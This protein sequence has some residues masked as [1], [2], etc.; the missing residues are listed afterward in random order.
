MTDPKSVQTS[1]KPDEYD[2]PQ[3]NTY[4]K[5]RSSH[6]GKVTVFKNYLESLLKSKKPLSDL[7]IIQLS[8]RLESYKSL[9]NEFDKNQ[10]LIDDIV[11]VSD[12]QLRE[13][14]QF[15]IE[16]Q[17][18]LALGIHLLR[19]NETAC[20]A[21]SV[22]TP[23]AG[24][25]ATKAFIKLPTIDLPH[26]SGEYQNW[27]EYRD[28]F[29]S[30]IHN[31]KSIDDIQ[32]F[33]YLRASLQGE[34]SDIIKSLEMS[35]HNYRVAWELITERYN[36]THQLIYNHL[37]ALF[38]IQNIEKESA[39]SL[40]Q[41]LD[42]VNKNLRALNNLGEP[43][44]DTILIYLITSKL[45]FT[46]LRYWKESSKNNTV[47]KPTLQDLK[48]YLSDRFMLLQN[49]EDT[50]NIHENIQQTDS[51][52]H[53]SKSDNKDKQS[54][55]PCP[56]CK[57][58]HFLF[59]CP[60]FKQMTVEKRI[61]KV[62]KFSNF[63]ANCLHNGHET[64]S[65]RGGACKYCQKK[66]NTMLHI[67]KEPTKDTAHTTLASNS[68]SQH[69]SVL[70]S[71]ALVHVI[72][73]DGTP[74][75]ARV[76][77]DSGSTSCYIT[78][79][80]S[81]KLNLT[82]EPIR[83]TVSGINQQHTKIFHRTN[84][85]IKSLHGSFTVNLSCLV[86]DTIAHSLPHMRINTQGLNI[87]KHLKLAD[88]QFYEP[89]PID[90]LLGADI[91]WQII[92]SGHIRLGKQQPTLQET[93]LG[94][95]VSGCTTNTDKHT[96]SCFFNNNNSD[97]LSRFWE[98]DSLSNS[99]I[100][101][102]SESDACE[103]IFTQTTTRQSDG[104]FVVNIPFK[105]SPDCL[106][107]S[108]YQAKKRFYSI[109]NRM[110]SN[111]TYKQQ[112]SN[113]ITEYIQLGHMTLNK[114]LHKN[115]HIH[116]EHNTSIIHSSANSTNTNIQHSPVYYLPHHGI[117]RESSTTTKFRAV[118]DGSAKTS[119]K[120]ALNDIQ[121]VG[122]VVQD[123][124]IS[125]LIRFRQHKYIIS[126]DI[127]K[128]FR[129]ITVAEHQ[130]PLQQIIWRYNPTEPL[131]TYMLNTVTYGTASAPFLATRCIKQIG[132]D[133][134]NTQNHSDSYD[135][136]LVSEIILHDF[137]CDD[138]LTGIDD[139]SVLLE[140]AKGVFSELQK[141][142]FPLRKWQSNCPAVL[143]KL[144]FNDSDST[145]FNLSSNDPSKTLGIYW[146]INKDTISYTVHSEFVSQ[147]QI[148]KRT[149]LSTI[150]HIFDPLGLISPCVL[151]AKLIMQQMWINNIS[152]DGEIPVSIQ[153]Q[154]ARFVE[155]LSFINHLSIPRR[156]FH[157][158][159]R[160]N[161]ELHIFCDASQQAYGACAYIRTYTPGGNINVQLLVAKGRVAPL[162]TL[163]IPRLEL[164]AA[165]TGVNLSNKVLNSL[166]N[167]NNCKCYY[168]SD[169]IIVLSWINSPTHKLQTFV[170][171]KVTD[172]L[173]HTE[174]QSWYYVPTKQNPAD[175]I[176][177]CTNAQQLLH[178][179]LWFSGPDFLR[180]DDNHSWP[181]QPGHLSVSDLPEVRSQTHLTHKHTIDNNSFIYKYSNFNKL[182]RIVAYILRFIHHCKH[183]QSNNIN[184]KTCQ[185]V[186]IGD[187]MPL[188]TSE[189]NSARYQLAKIVQLDFFFE[190]YQ[191]LLH[192]K[193]LPAS[194]RLN[195]L[196]PFIGD[197][198]LIRVGGRLAQSPFNYDRKFPILLHPAH[199]ITQIIFSTYHITLLHA[200]PQLLLSHIR[201]A[202]WPI[203]GRNLARKTTQS[204]VT[205]KRF[206][207][208]I[209][210]PIMG[211][212]PEQRL[213]ANFVFSDVGVD[214][215]GPIMINNR[216]GRGSVLIK[217]Y[218]CIFICF[219]V[220]AV[221]LELVTDLTTES[222]IA[223]IN[224][225]IS[226]RGKPNN[227]YSD[228][229]RN[230]VGAARVIT[231]FIRNHSESIY[232][233]AAE[234]GVNFHF[235][236]PYS[237]HFGGLWES[238]V[239]SV[240]HHLK[241][242]LGMA[243]LTYEEMYTLLVQIEGILNSRPLTPLSSDPSDLSALTPFHFLI[244]RTLTV[245]PHPQMSDCDSAR[246]PRHQRVELLRQ[247][248]WR[249]F[250]KEYISQLH[251]R[252]RWQRTQGA[253]TEGSLVI[254]KD[255]ALPVAQ[256]PLGRIVKLYPGHD[257]EA[258]VADI[259]IKTGTIRRAFHKIC[260]LL[261]GP[262]D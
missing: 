46:T 58:Q 29:E 109:E 4:K 9:A 238:T 186:C 108:Y 137:Y 173:K 2:I 13:R 74:H 139:E 251:Q 260:P 19:E 134:Q 67:H 65:C 190:E 224:R 77:L 71:T 233:C 81:T 174:P 185:Q 140:I 254:V 3:L 61:E 27:L 201:Q 207:G 49:L 40:R 205:C 192:N 221:H 37:H 261:D 54:R 231:N 128:M 228:N 160:D 72:A 35:S 51:K 64:K 122:P 55:I 235:I 249:R 188:S 94:W 240:K 78:N 175:I 242:V 86:L 103:I 151:E 176:T 143:N 182:T 157:D 102:P 257:G 210:T 115:T 206:K 241:R 168:W 45:D 248:F 66:H 193:Q 14:E 105:K 252:T 41:L 31:N 80:L 23:T 25:T 44:V 28:T 180:N 130:R 119:S 167:K 246:L 8:N 247:H 225:F 57:G 164:C 194:H 196:N 32:K 250:N 79:S 63:C 147:K 118:F 166:R 116:S 120:L 73:N 123:D 146:N 234:Q 1:N 203:S 222:Y 50:K 99:Q 148:T 117:I 106:G 230:L 227:I 138:L 189:L 101:D 53:T 52:S 181:E 125:I 170:K 16:Y 226:R 162:K 211:Q 39:T 36:N 69:T 239:K 113:F 93:E 156:A 215:A 153:Q 258:R 184:T 88:P 38:S 216:K 169:S 56:L 95:L 219:V 68:S 15:E 10:T 18:Q 165:F 129:Q 244:G 191:L 159:S 100:N 229:G 236:P 152:W 202:F 209:I 218:I 121:L 22:P 75:L 87:P 47:E 212:L 183:K 62:S 6:K 262:S 97:Q 172:I 82:L 84:V 90:I 144:G 112:Y 136:K 107:D 255:E 5:R 158:S 171:H 195:S 223:A 83:G 104:R 98:L 21:G 256:W 124:L 179:P 114:H 145:T 149:I 237:P 259:K 7:D 232:S 220:K 150:G 197:N 253:L 127:E 48:S 11:G 133:C 208:K 155:S 76:L 43:T 187:V 198:H 214:Y 135:H 111:H 142:Q 42:T 131:Q 243:N 20:V 200:G 24:D 141:Y 178:T 110:N 96:N 199:H 132:L 245:L 34:A 154:W 92:S 59:A 204:C 213:H 33:H 177:K 60:Q 12:E 91:F 89:A 161:I 17:Y 26:F 126:A 163:T 30:L 217:S 70:L 85:L